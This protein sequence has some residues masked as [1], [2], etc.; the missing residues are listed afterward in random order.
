MLNIKKLISSFKHAING[1]RQ[2]VKEEQNLQ[3]HIYISILILGAGLFFQ[4]RKW[5]FVTLILLIMAILVLE[6]VN[7]IFERLSDMLKP[8]IHTYVKTIKDI[9]AATVLVA[10]V[11]AIIIG[12]IIFY[13]YLASLV[14]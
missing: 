9:M 2:A 13:P 1:F 12:I 6:L 10:A 11:G 7:T 3:I 4:I 5:E 14:K 8:R